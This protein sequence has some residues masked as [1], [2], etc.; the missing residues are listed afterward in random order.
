MIKHGPGTDLENLDFEAI[1]K[2]IEED[3]AAQASAQTAA[4]TG[5]EP[6]QVD[7]D[8][9]GT[10]QAWTSKFL[11]LFF[12]FYSYL[13][14]WDAPPIFWGFSFEQL[15]LYDM[16]VSLIDISCLP[17]TYAWMFILE[18]FVGKFTCPRPFVDL[19]RIVPRFLLRCRV[20]N[21]NRRALLFKESLSFC[22]GWPMST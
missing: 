11:F 13:D 14:T 22:L 12:Y 9:G 4:S 2:E 19:R 16:P 20:L 18:N 17:T 6:S 15:T 7:R 10:P 21:F 5:I 8:D 1:D 3:E